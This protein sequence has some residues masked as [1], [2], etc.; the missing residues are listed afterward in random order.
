MS[1][2]QFSKNDIFVNTLKTYPDVSFLIYDRQIYYNNIPS[3]SLQTVQTGRIDLFQYHFSAY[4]FVVKNG[5]RNSFRYISDNEYN[6]LQY[7]TR[8]TGSYPLSAGIRSTYL[9][10]NQSR[11]RM[12]IFT[13]ILTSSYVILSPHFEPSAGTWNKASQEMRMFEIPSIFV[14]S[15]IKKGSVSCKFFITGTLAGEL[16]DDKQN[17]E[18]RQAFP[19]DSN[20]GSVAGVV[21]YNHA[22]ILLT[23]SWVINNTIS[24][25]YTGA[26]AATPRWID[27]GT[28]GSA[29]AGTN[30]PSS[31][32]SLFFQGVH[33]IPTLMMFAHLPKGELN[34]SNNPSFITYGQTG[35]AVPLTSSIDYKEFSNI[36]IKNINKSNFTNATA[37]FENIV[38][39]SGIK[40]Y[41]KNR[42]VIAVA[43]LANPIKKKEKD[44]YSIKL[45]L[46]LG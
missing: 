4:P 33:S 10:L 19:Q 35:S 38:F 39:V 8:I 20:S 9:P 36:S 18:L 5:D 29:A 24:E 14:G 21:L 30:C 44:G 6:N 42:N 40:I 7:G 27:F 43:K 2:Y 3:Q 1:L 17:G 34:Y 37:S 11:P 12:D 15:S 41:D 13:N 32:F 46:D 28:T 25:N 16:R 26:G 45:K 31:S 22:T 23:G